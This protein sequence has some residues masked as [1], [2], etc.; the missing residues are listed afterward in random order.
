MPD[1]PIGQLRGAEVD[2]NYVGVQNPCFCVSKDLSSFRQLLASSAYPGVSPTPR[3]LAS[4]LPLQQSEPQIPSGILRLHE[5]S[6]SL[7]HLHSARSPDCSINSTEIIPVSLSPSHD[8]FGGGSMMVW[9]GISMEGRTDLYRLDNG[10]LTAIRYRDE[11]LGPIVRPYAGAEGPGFLLVHDNTWPHSWGQDSL[12]NN[13]GQTVP[14]HQRDEARKQ[15]STA[16]DSRDPGRMWQGIQVIMN[17]KTTSPACDSDASLPDALNDFYA[18]FKAQNSIVV[19]KTIPPPHDQVLCF[20]TADMKTTLCRVN[21]QKEQTTFL[22][23]WS[24]NVQ[25]SEWKSPL[26]SSTS[27]YFPEQCHCSYMPQDNDHRHRAEEI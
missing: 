1:T 24:G 8:Q 14:S 12:K 22:A 5:H 3:L 18:W 23:E 20:S 11:I 4:T 27:P 21:P 26:T 16:T 17:Y 9:G 10:T 2:H 6:S 19:R 25:Y 13:K 15:E 7:T